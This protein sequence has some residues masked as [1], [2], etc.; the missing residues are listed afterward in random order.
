MEI[1]TLV[2]TGDQ[3]LDSMLAFAKGL[4]TRGITNGAL[5]EDGKIRIFM[6]PTTAARYAKNDPSFQDDHDAVMAAIKAAGYERR[7]GSGTASKL[8]DVPVAKPEPATPKPPVA[9]AAKS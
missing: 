9:A 7:D 8:P 4:I 3:N 2:P 5:K 6:L 1:I